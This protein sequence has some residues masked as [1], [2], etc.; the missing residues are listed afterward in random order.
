[1]WQPILTGS[2]VTCAWEAIEAVAQD[3][4]TPRYD[5]GYLPSSVRRAAEAGLPGG[6]AG[7]AVFY[8]HLAR[9][10]PDAGHEESAIRFLEEAIDGVAAT[11]MRAGL[12]GGFAGVAWAMAHL[13]DWLLE[14]KGDDP[15]RSIDAA[16][17][18][19]LR[20]PAWNDDYD[21]IGGLVGL[22]VY[23]VERVTRG[24]S[25]A[26]AAAC[27]ERVVDHLDALASQCPDGITWLTP[28]EHLEAEDRARCPGGYY[29][30]GVAHGVPGV[31]GLLGAV[32]APELAPYLAPTTVETARR[33]LDGTVPWLLRQQLDGESGA[34]FAYWVGPG[35]EPTPA[36]SGWCY[37][38]PG[39]AAALLGA[40]R[41][42]GEPAWEQDAVA[43]ARFTVARPAQES[44]VADPGFCHG[45]AGL[46]H[47]FNRIFQATGDPAFAKGARFWFERTLAMRRPGRGIGGF[48][49]LARGGPEG[50][51]GW[52]DA[53]GLLMG[54]AGI[55][56]ALLAAVTPLEPHWD[57]IF[58]AEIPLP[59]VS[60]GD[61]P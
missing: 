40:A 50:A 27:L 16:L 52:C 61:L 43:V 29:N 51:W 20:Q 45:A 36:R 17:L 23:A 34:R 57:R 14:T 13:M 39:V 9:A 19:R 47:L 12:H 37:G 55:A 28:P 46:G 7:I 42:A 30:L 35:I 58:L 54:S 32:L 22:G 33:L 8:A 25:G 60:S 44:C 31:I 11:P 3:L 15:T 59:A 4:H 10:R 6:A 26:A 18:E 38:D 53:P 41:Q 1:M 2:L 56:L 49:A 24:G 5:V 21:L 48:Q